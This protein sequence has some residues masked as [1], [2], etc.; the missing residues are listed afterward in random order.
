MIRQNAHTASRLRD[1]RLWFVSL[2]DAPEVATIPDQDDDA[3]TA[4]RDAQ[5]VRLTDR[6]RAA[7]EAYRLARRRRRDEEDTWISWM[8]HP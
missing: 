6:E 5:A 7:F 3:R 2:E 8:H 1:E 4:L